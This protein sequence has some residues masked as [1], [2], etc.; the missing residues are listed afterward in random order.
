MGIDIFLNLINNKQ[1]EFLKKIGVDIYKD[2]LDKIEDK[3]FDYLQ[4]NGI[5]DDELNEIGINCEQILDIIS[6][7]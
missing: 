4:E 3:V 1:K 7:I 2:N 6:G 5:E